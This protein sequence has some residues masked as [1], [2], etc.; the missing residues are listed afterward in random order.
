MKWLPAAVLLV[1]AVH[2]VNLLPTS[3]NFGRFAFGDCGW[4]LTVDAMLDDGLAPVTDFAYFYGLFTLVI[5]RVL[6][7]C[8]GR[9]PE[10][11][12]VLYGVCTL[13]VAIGAVRVMASL[14]LHPL[15]AL[16]PVVCAALFTVPRGFPS[17]AHALEAALLMNAL[18]DHA[19]GKLRRALALTVVAVFVKP[20][21]G[22]F[23]GLILLVLIF[24]KR[25]EGASR[26]H[27]LLPATGVGVA[28]LLVLVATFG[29]HAVWRTQIPTSGMRVYGD[30]GHG[31]FFGTGQ[32][33][34]WPEWPHWHYY[35]DGVPGVW[36]ASSAVLLATAARLVRRWR[37]PL[38]GFVTTCA[39]LHLVFVSLL[40]GNRWSW[41]YYPYILFVGTAAALTACPPRWRIVFT[42]ALIVLA[43]FGQ[44]KWLWL[45]D[46]PKWEQTRPSPETGGLYATPDEIAEWGEVRRLAATSRVLVLTPM[47]CSQLLAPEVAGP[48]WWCLMRQIMTDRERARVL[49]SINT[50]D[51]VFSP[52]WHDNDV[53]RWPEF[54]EALRP[55]DPE[56]PVRETPLGKLY[57]RR[58]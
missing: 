51:W 45:D 53:M 20:A 5:D 40:F 33:F 56:H 15:P 6:F 26:W 37:E 16:Y 28:V 55:F 2:F 29:W 35:L 58:R 50:A 3:L 42:L 8:L 27:A 52:N 4:P 7:A 30:S 57:E 17:P 32:L 24:T 31:F 19:A 41:I 44:R 10:V 38:A 47:G 49:D 22:Y 54:A 21:L 34:W 46:Y 39:V 12:V 36:L 14:K 9:S 48:R 23:Y 25:S 13:A 43:V 11:V 18:A 1:T